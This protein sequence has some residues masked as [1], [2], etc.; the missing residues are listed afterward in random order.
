MAEVNLE[1]FS[2]RLGSIADSAST[3]PN[4][5]CNALARR[6]AGPLRIKFCGSIYG[7]SGYSETSRAFVKALHRA[8]VEICVEPVVRERHRPDLGEDAALFRA[9]EAPP[10]RHNV[11]IINVTPEQFRRYAEPDCI[12]IGYTVFETDRIPE[13]WVRACNALDGILVMS[14]W[15]RKVFQQSGVK[16]PVKSAPPGVDADRFSNLAR[17]ADFDWLDYEVYG[18][19]K[20]RWTWK[21]RLRSMLGKSSADYPS[22]RPTPSSSQLNNAFKFYSIFQWTERKNPAGLLKAYFAEF[23]RETDVCLVLKTYGR[24][25]R[26]KHRAWIRQQIDEA[27]R[28]LRIP[29]YPPV[30]LVLEM[31]SSDDVLKLHATSDCFVLPHRAEGWGMPHIE[32][33]ACGKPVIT[34]GYSGNLEFTR[35]DNSFLVPYQMTPVCN[36]NWCRWYEGDMSWAEPDLD[37]LRRHMRQVYADRDQA[38]RIGLRGRDFVRRN[39]NWPRRAEDMMA[40]IAEIAMR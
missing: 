13:A 17:P 33:M 2:P 39:F 1:M 23:H 40:A 25:F 6:V 9:L 27:A 19:P 20:P 22:R 28:S 10:L 7:P 21:L 30:L 16:V 35:P 26:G 29:K 18:G 5:V 37:A 32:A 11:K 14:D 34:T 24:S 3:A 38:R 4:G 36:M 31:L 12:N 8:G 15:C